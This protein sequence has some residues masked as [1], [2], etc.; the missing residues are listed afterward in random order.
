MYIYIHTYVCVKGAA[1]PD[2]H[3]VLRGRHRLRRR[4][5]R[6]LHHGAVYYIIY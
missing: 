3:R 6:L 2:R 5:Q 4:S 1:I